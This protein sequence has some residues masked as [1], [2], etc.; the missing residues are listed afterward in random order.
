M[1]K[2]TDGRRTIGITMR[3]LSE[4]GYSPDMSADFFETGGLPKTED[5]ET[6]VVKDVSYCI[7]RAFDWAYYKGEFFNSEA[8][9]YNEEHGFSRVAS[10]EAV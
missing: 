6:C 5:G 8:E 2:L 10:V 4:S 3:I 1:T 7:D 9:A